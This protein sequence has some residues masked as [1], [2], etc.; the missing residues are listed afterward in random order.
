MTLNSSSSASTARGLG[1]YKPPYLVYAVLGIEPGPCACE[2][3]NSTHG[4]SYV[5]M[6]LEV[7][8]LCA[9][10][11][12]KP[13]WGSEFLG[14]SSAHLRMLQCLF[15]PAM[16]MA[17]VTGVQWHLRAIRKGL[18]PHPTHPVLTTPLLLCTPLHPILLPDH[19]YLVSLDVSILVVQWGWL[20]GHIQLCGSG[21]VD[22]HI[23][24]CCCGHWRAQRLESECS[25]L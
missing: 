20:P 14:S 22:G 10:K 3:N 4:A 12:T 24:R 23:L 8:A 5:T 7:W 25:W 15:L 6:G 13:R 21:T 1:L 16:H 19:P 17:K 2:A 9:L 18:G 11:Q